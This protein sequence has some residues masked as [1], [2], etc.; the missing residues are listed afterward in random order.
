MANAE[1]KDVESQELNSVFKS[2]AGEPEKSYEGML[3]K[4]SNLLV[5]RFRDTRIGVEV[6][7]RFNYMV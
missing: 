7:L 6:K 5:P 1:E 3:E 4:L 2:L